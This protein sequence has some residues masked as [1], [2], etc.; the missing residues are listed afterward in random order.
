M[1]EFK[2]TFGAQPPRHASLA[3]MRQNLAW[4]KQAIFKGIAPRTHREQ[5]LRKLGRQLHGKKAGLSRNR[6]GTR[7]VREWRGQLYEVTVETGGYS[8]NGQL[9]SNLSRIA[10]EITGTKW[11]GPRFF[12]LVGPQ[13]GQ[14]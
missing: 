14:T 10:T 9:Y 11:S 5:L 3:L 8:W 7:L 1:A 12:G 4:A 2:A 6:P 13:N